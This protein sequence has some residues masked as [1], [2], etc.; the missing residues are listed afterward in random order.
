MALW[1]RKRRASES[2]AS[3]LLATGVAAHRAGD[4]RGAERACRRALAMYRKLGDPGRSGAA[5]AV[6]RLALVR[7]ARGRFT[8]ALAGGTEAARRWEALLHD[9]AGLSAEVARCYTELAAVA[10]A[11]G[12][13]EEAIGFGQRA[14]EL[15]A[16][17]VRDG[18]PDGDPTLGVA[19]HSLALQLRATGEVGRAA[20]VAAEA[21]ASRGR[22][23][24]SSPHPSLADWDYANS[25]LLSG[26]LEADLGRPDRAAPALLRARELAAP[27]GE[28]GAD[29][30]ARVAHEL[31][32][33]GGQPARF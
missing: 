5:R 3:T 27:L 1:G 13:P 14:V 20:A 33:I 25:L 29:V 6:W 26:T 28:A 17:A 7:A 16:R 31:D 4:S 9:N 8:L 30:V 32:R 22:L 23:S 2:N 10:A 24:D 11:G 15:S 21:V 19:A 18:D 12:Q